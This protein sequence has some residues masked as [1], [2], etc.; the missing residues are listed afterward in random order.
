VVT[1]VASVV[2]F[3]ASAKGLQDGD[4]VP[5][6]AITGTAASVAGIVGGII[7]FGDPLPGNP[8]VL[9]VQCLAFGFVVLAAWL[10]PAPVRAAPGALA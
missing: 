2:A 8:L 7:V 10:M 9:V 1:V 3:F 5:V 4:A 6:I